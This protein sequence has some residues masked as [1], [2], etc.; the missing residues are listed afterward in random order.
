[1]QLASI[2]N[3]YEKFLEFIVIV[4]MAGLA[5]EVTV[6]VI[7]RTAGYSLVWYDEVASILLAW[8]T[9][10]GAALAAH[11]RAHI[12]FSGLVD[13]LRPA[14]RVPAMMLAE[15]CVIGFFIL[16]AY[17]GWGVMDVLATDFL[18]SIP[19]VSVKYTQSVIP[20]SAVLFVIAELFALP[21]LLAQARR[22][23]M[24]RREP[25]YEVN[26]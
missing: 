16:L 4:L 8:L 7:F 2:R 22:P 25:A 9:F 12:G 3:A 26:P 5:I 6:G 17:V 14:L 20:I 23:D 21:H 18:V 19:Q 10:Y 13:S 15:A 11:K 24:L 1:M